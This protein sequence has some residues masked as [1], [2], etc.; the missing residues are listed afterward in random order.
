MKLITSQKAIL[1][2]WVLL[3]ITF[4][5]TLPANA[6]PREDKFQ[7]LLRQAKTSADQE[8]LF[9]ILPDYGPDAVIPSLK[10]FENPFSS[11]QQKKVAGTIILSLPLT[12]PVMDKIVEA[13]K[14]GRYYKISSTS[15][16][17]GLADVVTQTL[18][19]WGNFLKVRL[20]GE[21]KFVE[22]LGKKHLSSPIGQDTIIELMADAHLPTASV[23]F[24]KL[25]ANRLNNNSLKI[26]LAY[27][28]NE[29]DESARFALFCAIFKNLQPKKREVEKMIFDLDEFTPEHQRQFVIANIAAM[30]DEERD[31]AIYI[32]SKLPSYLRDD[33]YKKIEGSCTEKQKAMMRYDMTGKIK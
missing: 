1:L 24:T 33:I 31:N 21:K 27:T 12:E 32:S 30:T 19:W 3:M 13:Y 15:N 4:V 23:Y 8:R 11:E 25:N 6:N 14:H 7:N 29:A 10:Q 18:S 2:V 17:I 22:Y 5:N 26:L 20:K 9:R 16:T 28:H